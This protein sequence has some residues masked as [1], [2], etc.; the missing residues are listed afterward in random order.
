MTQDRHCNADE[1][2]QDEQ[3]AEHENGSSPGC[4]PSRGAKVL[5]QHDRLRH[6]GRARDTRRNRGRGQESERTQQGEVAYRGG[7]LYTFSQDKK[8]GDVKGNGFKDVGVWR[9]ATLLAS[10]PAPPPTTTSGGYGGGYG[11]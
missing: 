9:P 2:P 6:C 8:P 5:P 11:P 7:P 4:G 1:R 3:C 10:A